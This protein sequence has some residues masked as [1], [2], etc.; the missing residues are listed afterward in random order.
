MLSRDGKTRGGIVHAGDMEKTAFFEAKEKG[1]SAERSSQ[2][3]WFGPSYTAHHERKYCRS[4]GTSSAGV[5][6]AKGL[7]PTRQ[8]S[9][10]PKGTAVHRKQAWCTGHGISGS[11]ERPPHPSW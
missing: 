1:R 7:G 5:G 10:G 8:G 9:G 11:W 2:T 6:P 4:L 3:L